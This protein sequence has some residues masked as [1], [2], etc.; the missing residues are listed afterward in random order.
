MLNKENYFKEIKDKRL[1]RIF[2]EVINRENAGDKMFE[3]YVSGEKGDKEIVKF[4]KNDAGPGGWCMVNYMGLSYEDVKQNMNYP[5]V[6]DKESLGK[7]RLEGAAVSFRPFNE[8]KRVNYALSPDSGNIY[9]SAFVE[10]RGLPMEYMRYTELDYLMMRYISTDDTKIIS[11]SKGQYYAVRLLKDEIIIETIKEIE[12][13]Y[14]S[15]T[16]NLPIE[17]YA[18][19][20][21][22][23]IIN[24]LDIIE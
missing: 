15:Y 8:V 21:Y 20:E 13:R 11:D 6:F 18:D 12:D 22:K 7:Y 19:L 10:A 14:V 4:S 5:L 1:V 23:D 9:Q 2:D 24:S 17:L 16:I 3:I